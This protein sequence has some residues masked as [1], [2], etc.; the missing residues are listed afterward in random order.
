MVRSF[1][2]SPESIGIGLEDSRTWPMA[3]AADFFQVKC[4]SARQAQEFLTR[5]T[6]YL[7]E[8]T[9]TSLILRENDGDV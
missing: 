3:T 8:M 7:E 5:G 4:S 1:R 2:Q 9:V 6:C